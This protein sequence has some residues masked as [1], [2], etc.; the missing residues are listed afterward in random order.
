MKD[1]DRV[2]REDGA[3]HCQADGFQ[4]WFL[5]DNYFAIKR[6][7]VDRKRILDLGCGEGCLARYVTDAEID[8]VDYS[9]RAIVLN[10][11]LFPGRYRRLFRADLASLG[12]LALI[13]GSYDCIVCSLTLM[14]LDG[15][16]LRRCLDET[17]RLLT[18]GGVFVATYPTVGPHRQGSP[19]AAE[20]PPAALE[21]A[22]E[23]V[24]YRICTM[25]PSCPF[26]PASVVEQSKNEVTR[27]SAHAKYIA[28]AAQMKLENSYHFLIVGQK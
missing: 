13:A 28:A 21:I 24:G 27:E 25:E 8:G 22:L 11:N 4:A 23:D 5:A 19:E 14:Y 9:D 18:K 1:F 16:N 20:I 2:Y 6:Q 7:C 10:R 15:P 17:L 3:Y 26:L 12:D